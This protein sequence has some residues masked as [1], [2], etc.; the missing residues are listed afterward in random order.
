MSTEVIK[1]KTAEGLRDRLFNAL[2]AVIEKKI[3][4]EDV[5]SICYVSDQILKTA[6]HELDVFIEFERVE[7]QKREDKRIEKK[8]EKESVLMLKS[9]I[10]KCCE[11]TNEKETL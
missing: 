1:E 8:E 6:R 11:L 10:D 7:K 4:K 5:E 3:S 9:T 2:D